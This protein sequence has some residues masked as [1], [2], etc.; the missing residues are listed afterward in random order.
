MPQSALSEKLQVKTGCRIAVLG[1][2]PGYLDLLAPLPEGVRVADA[3][4]GQYDI[5]HAFFEKLDDLLAA[6]DSLKAALVDGGILWISYPKLT[7]K[8]GSDLN[9][10]L[11]WKAL[12]ERGLKAVSQIAV[13]DVWS[14][15]RFKKV[16]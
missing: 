15:M 16:E 12:G 11:I 2:P 10:D 8:R 6:V 3:L 1:A 9:R 4:S 14:A 5:V 7:A 13:D